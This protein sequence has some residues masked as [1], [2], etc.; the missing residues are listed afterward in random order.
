MNAPDRFELFLLGEGEKKCE[1]VPFTA[2]PN[3]SDFVIK[4]EDHT[5]GNLVSE[6][7]KKHRN[8]LMAGYKVSH[9]NV[10]E[11]FIRIQ[12]DGTI[13]PKEAL[14]SVLEKLLRD[15]NHLSQEFTR[16]WE[17]R[18][19]VTEGEQNQNGI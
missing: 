8:V 14:L 3:C 4:K 9:P 18:R 7:L 1:E 12:T 13:T 15:L 19:M 5:I 11:L 17:L 2:I 10:P 16:E 6:Q